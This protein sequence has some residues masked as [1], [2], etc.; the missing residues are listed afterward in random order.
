MKYEF[1]AKFTRSYHSL[2][3]KIQLKFDKQLD[4]LLRNVRH[5]SLHAKKYNEEEGVWQA[6]V[7]KS[8]RFFFKINDDVYTLL[9]IKNHPK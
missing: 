2:P 8:F 9:N 4:Y 1:T 7:D 5:P 6:R 3:S